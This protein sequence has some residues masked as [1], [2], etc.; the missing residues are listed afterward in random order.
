MLW[1]GADPVARVASQVSVSGMVM[2]LRATTAFD[3]S[4]A[5]S[6]VMEAFKKRT[7]A[8]GPCRRRHA[9]IAA[10]LTVADRRVVL[11]S[12]ECTVRP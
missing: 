7:F 6:W 11:L 5:S 4:R 12:K 9:R 1:H 10:P 8:K 3:P 2:A